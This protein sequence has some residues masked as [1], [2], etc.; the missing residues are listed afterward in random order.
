M[1]SATCISSSIVGA[2]SIQTVEARVEG[3]TTNKLPGVG[4]FEQDES[5]VDQIEL[6]VHT[7]LE[8]FCDSGRPGN[9]AWS[10]IMSLHGSPHGSRGGGGNPSFP[11]TPLTVRSTSRLGAA[12]G[13]DS[14]GGRAAK[15]QTGLIEQA[16]GLLQGLVLLVRAEGPGAEPIQVGDGLGDASYQLRTTSRIGGFRRP[17]FDKY[18]YRDLK[19]QV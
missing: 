6:A 13:P 4:R 18:Q 12:A 14:A 1:H 15:P 3:L 5:A 11:S 2:K 10:K 8:G 17:F 19:F 7:H 9:R 16:V